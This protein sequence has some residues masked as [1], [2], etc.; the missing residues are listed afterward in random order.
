MDGGFRRVHKIAKS[1]YKLRHA[2]RSLRPYARNNLAPTGRIFVELNISVFF[3]NLLIKFKFP[4]IWQK[5]WDLYMKINLHLTFICLRD[6]SLS[7]DVAH[8]TVRSWRQ[9]SFGCFSRWPWNTLSNRTCVA[10]RSGGKLSAV[11]LEPIQNRGLYRTEEWL[12]KGPC[13]PIQTS[14]TLKSKGMLNTLNI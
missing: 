12:Y 2:C 3:K 1:N 7:Y 8:R 11:F 10:G 4:K 13:F 14:M 5:Q 6:T 9:N